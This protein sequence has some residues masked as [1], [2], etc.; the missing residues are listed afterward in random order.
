MKSRVLLNTVML[1]LLLC[2]SCSHFNRTR[3]TPLSP[4]S[5]YGSLRGDWPMGMTT[6]ISAFRR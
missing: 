6:A 1:A 4:E 2:T 3:A 5:S